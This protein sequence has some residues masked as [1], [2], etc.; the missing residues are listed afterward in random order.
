MEPVC[1][2][3]TGDRCGEG[4]VWHPGAQALYW[5]DI[6]RFLIHRFEPLHGHVA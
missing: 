1:V 6:G 4:P 2:A 5:T 3:P